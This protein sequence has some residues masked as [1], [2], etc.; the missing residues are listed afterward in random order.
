M[1]QTDARFAGAGTRDSGIGK[2]TSPSGIVGYAKQ[3]YHPAYERL[4]NSEEFL[5]KLVPVLIV[6]FLVIIATARWVQINT[7][8]QQIVEANKAELYFIAELVEA[9]LSSQ[10]T[11][12]PEQMSENELQ[13]MLNDNVP[14]RYVQKDRHVILS[15]VDGVIRATLPRKR[16]YIGKHLNSIFENSLLLS[17]FGKLADSRYILVD[18]KEQALGVHRLL[19]GPYGGITV[20]QPT[21]P[22]MEIWRRNVSTNVTL[23]VGTSSILLVILYAY[24]A[25]ST[26]AREA[27]EIYTTTQRR[28]DTALQ[29]GRS[30]LW[31]WDISRGRIY[32]SDSMYS[33]L[34]KQVGPSVL[35]FSEISNLIHP[36]DPDLHSLADMVLVENS[37]AVD[38]V[39]RMR[40]EDEQWVWIR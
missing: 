38:K 1:A 33:I 12:T 17:R 15:D 31:D 11:A 22:M 27:D 18:G 39:F 8:G 34:G 3:L 29:R 35:S 36:N 32:W 6:V 16:E 2:K 13:N 24:F 30:G 23:F 9:K 26:R 37:E 21:A 4:L 20:Y 25:Q 19:P 5:R 40:H 10:V 7:M 14:A 28:F